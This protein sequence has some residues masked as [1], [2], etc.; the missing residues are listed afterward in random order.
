M[1]F[2]EI[3][4][5]LFI[6]NNFLNNSNL[7]N[8]F[9]KNNLFFYKNFNKIY[10]QKSIKEVTFFKYKRKKIKKNKFFKLRKQKDRI[11]NIYLNV[12][13]SLNK[14]KVLNRE[15]YLNKHKLKLFLIF[16]YYLIDNLFFLKSNYKKIN[17]NNF[18]HVFY[19]NYKNYNLFNF[20]KDLV[21]FNFY[22]NLNYNKNN[23]KFII[24][25]KNK[26][27]KHIKNIKFLF[28]NYSLLLDSYF[29]NKKYYSYKI[30]FVKLFYIFD[31]RSK[32]NIY[33]SFNNKL[34]K[35]NNFDNF[36][37][38]IFSVFKNITC[39]N[40]F[41]SNNIIFKNNFM[42]SNFFFFKNLFILEE[43][44][45]D[46]LNIN[47]FERNKKNNLSLNFYNN[48][49]PIFYSHKKSYK[50]FMSKFKSSLNLNYLIFTNY[51]VITFLEKLFKK[52]FFLKLSNNF[53]NKP[54]KQFVLNELYNDYKNFQPKYM[55]GFS[56][57][58]FFEI[59]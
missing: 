3:Y 25:N 44:F 51:Y 58:D 23:L 6:K 13:K 20:Y 52:R 24:K 32:K 54:S 31:L 16:N 2:K 38:L 49:Y 29:I 50:L 57:K 59:I 27:I 55:K 53:F 40:D 56:L 43:N 5:N 45:N 10:L 14:K 22:N 12:F 48:Y 34:H 8:I 36:K 18:K 37:K 15:F 28:F 30:I 1:K 35:I 7:Y 4:Q 11:N 33:Y 19:C 17:Y 39:L 46:S 47:N 42:F 9:I 41:F 26:Q 21:F